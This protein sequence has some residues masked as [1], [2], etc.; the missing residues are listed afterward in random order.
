VFLQV[1]QDEAQVVHH[2]DPAERV[3]KL[4]PIEKLDAAVPPN[5]VPQVQVTMAIPH[6][7][8]SPAVLDFRPQ[9][10]ELTFRLF[11]ERL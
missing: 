8:N 3:I 7:S 5:Q 4:D 10:V 6:K 2:V 9:G 1:H 11:G